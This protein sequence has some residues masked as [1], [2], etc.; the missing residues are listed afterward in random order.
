MKNKTI[1]NLVC[2]WCDRD[3]GEKDGKGETGT[4]HGICK[5]CKETYF[6]PEALRETKEWYGNLS[7]T[8]E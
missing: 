8:S 1:M 6:S 5:E 2:A 4:S 7:N 3:L